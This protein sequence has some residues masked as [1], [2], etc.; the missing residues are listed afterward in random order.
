MV[1]LRTWICG[2]MIF[3]AV[4]TVQAS[5]LR[6]AG[7][8][9]PTHAWTVYCQETGDCGNDPA[10]AKRIVLTDS[11][12]L[13]LQAINANINHAFEA[14]PDILDHWDDPRKTG[15]ADCEDFQILKRIKLVEIGFPHRALLMTV[16]IDGAGSGHAVLTVRTDRGDYILDNTTDF[17]LPWDKTG[18]QFIKR[19]SQTGT[20]WVKLDATTDRSGTASTS[21]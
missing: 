8:A 16:V 21:D 4:S 20:Q 14:V 5:S 6:E 18:Y 2:F 19:E 13:T 15:K 12:M 3:G 11:V 7:P 10:E 17:V 1:Q 9:L